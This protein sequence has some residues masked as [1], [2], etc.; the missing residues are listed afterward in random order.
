[1]ADIYKIAQSWMSV[2]VHTGPSTSY[3][4]VGVIYGRNN[5]SYTVTDR[6]NSY[7]LKIGEGRWACDRDWNGMIVMVKTGSTN[8]QPA[9]PP[10]DPEPKQVD[11]QVDEESYAYVP[12]DYNSNGVTMK[13][14]K[15]SLDANLTISNLRGIFGMPYQFMAVADRRLTSNSGSIGR[16]YGKEIVASM[17]L[18]LMTAGL[19]VFMAEY[20]DKDRATILSKFVQSASGQEASIKEVVLS[21]DFGKYYSLRYAYEEYFEY[22]NPMCRVAA[23]M[24]N[25]QDESIDGTKLDEYVW[26]NNVNDHFNKLFSIYRHCI[27][28]YC[29]SDTSISDN[30]T[31][32]TSESMIG[33]KVNSLSD[34]GREFQFLLGTINSKTE[35]GS[36]LDKFTDSKALTDSMTAINDLVADTL[37]GGSVSN[38][39]K[40]LTS[41]IQTVV[42]GGKLVFPEL[43]SDSSF[44][45]SYD[46]KLKLVTPDADDLSVYLNI[47]VPILHLMAFVLPR[48]MDH[49]HGYQSP[50]LVRAFYKGLF[51]VD[52]GI[53]TD[54]S[55]TKGKESAWTPSGVPSIVEVSFTI[56]DLYS[57]MYMTSM[58]SMKS[59]MM[60][61]IILM[62]YISN[63][64]GVNINE[65]DVIRGIDLFLTQNIKNRITDIWHM[66]I[67][68]GLDQYITNKVQSIF[69]KF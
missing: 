3:P 12:S 48:E 45:R 55:I 5:E 59:N 35:S 36:L 40:S 19:P 23:R 4:H 21:Q 10:P 8:T 69:G 27:A 49:G 30:W 52:M 37:G 65:M 7:W 1:M 20:S 14:F 51:N 61:N 2:W 15:D 68:V 34:Y 50:F 47:I 67:H 9:A 38:I 22:V 58:K 44:S 43:W 24:M 66:K 63:L 46:V 29:D 28:F 11:E 57:D 33:Q 41:S 32:G 17:P 18:L 42:S 13:E 54:L 39:F 25:L 26:A 31:N 60:N 16:K 53:M 62:D 64:C 6:Q 56:K